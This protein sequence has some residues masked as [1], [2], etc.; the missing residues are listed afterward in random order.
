[1]IYA[2][3]NTKGGVGK[4]T[5]AVHL[6]TMLA[7]T[8]KTLIIDGDPQASAASWSTWRQENPELQPS[9]TTVCLSGKAVL[10]EGKKLEA[11]Y[12]NI[13]V[14]AGGKDNPSLRSA[15]LVA[16]RA[17]VPIGASSFDTAALSD[18]LSILQDAREFKPDLEVRVLLTRCDFRVVENSKTLDYLRFE[19][20]IVLPTFVA[21]RVAYKRAAERGSMVQE[22]EKPNKSASKE[23]EAFLVE[24]TCSLVDLEK[25]ILNY[26]AV[27]REEGLPMNGEAAKLLV[28]RNR[29]TK[30]EVVK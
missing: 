1:M 10:V 17:I 4:S 13:V 28:K 12:D 3:V 2:V 6:A 9:P 11:N 26:K 18:M 27:C 15:L 22:L 25:R 8:G 30:L 29:K 19:K 7:R 16:D 21:D 20:L 14:D 5:T 23:M 24:A